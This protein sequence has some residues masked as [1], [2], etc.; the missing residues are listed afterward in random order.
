MGQLY[1]HCSSPK[2]VL[3]DRRGT[4]IRDLGE[5]KAHAVNVVRSLLGT[6]GSEDWRR[7]VLHVSDDLGDEMFVMPFAFALSKP[8]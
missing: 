4:A 2:G 1:F 8:H 6:R 3:I 7:W 5:A